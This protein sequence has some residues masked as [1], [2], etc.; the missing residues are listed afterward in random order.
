MDVYGIFPPNTDMAVGNVAPHS[1]AR[2][3]R[4]PDDPDKTHTSHQRE[5]D[6]G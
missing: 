5:L 2:F 6:P 4:V 1:P 3:M